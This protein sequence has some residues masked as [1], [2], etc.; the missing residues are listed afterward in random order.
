MLIKA[1][2]T[3]SCNFNYLT[4]KEINGKTIT[5]INGS[6]NL[7]QDSKIIEHKV[8]RERCMEFNDALE[9]NMDSFDSF[10]SAK[11]TCCT[12]YVVTRTRKFNH[13][14]SSDNNATM[15]TRF[16]GARFSQVI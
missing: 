7:Y 6:K 2:K 9:G 10:E 4:S 8:S 15:V 16:Q 3:K 1:Q 11:F 5:F 14:I 12:M 13:Q